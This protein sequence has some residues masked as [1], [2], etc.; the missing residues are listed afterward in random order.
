MRIIL[1]CFWLLSAVIE[2]AIHNNV[3]KLFKENT[4]ENL[5]TTDEIPKRLVDFG[6][7]KYSKM[8]KASSFI[9][10]PRVNYEPI[11]PVNK[12]TIQYLPSKKYYSF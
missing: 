9:E 1:D 2:Y 7:E 3:Y 11:F 6:F 5:D 12:V 10:C 8:S 4:G